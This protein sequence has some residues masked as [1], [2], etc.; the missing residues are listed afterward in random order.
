M[1]L[2]SGKTRVGARKGSLESSRRTT[3]A[4]GKLKARVQSSNNMP[5]GNRVWVDNRV[6]CVEGGVRAG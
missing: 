5:V 2:L 4:T 3:T 1:S 6:W